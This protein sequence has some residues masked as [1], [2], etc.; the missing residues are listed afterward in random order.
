MTASVNYHSH[1]SKFEFGGPEWTQALR[2]SMQEAFYESGEE[3]K[4]ATFSM[5]EQYVGAPA[6]LLAAGGE[7]GWHV[8]FNDGRVDFVFSPSRDVDVYISADYQSILPLARLE[9]GSDK[10]KLAE[11]D[12]MVGELV[13]SGQ[14]VVEGDL[15]SR[16]GFLEGIHDAMARVTA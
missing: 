2:S 12:R 14:L 1:M 7:L 10:E 6:H 11:R 4:R 9:F 15:G 8:R 5:S 16:P 3:G 13:G